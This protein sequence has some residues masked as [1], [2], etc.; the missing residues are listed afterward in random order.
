MP[1][2]L[3]AS[4]F[5]GGI[6]IFVAAEW[7]AALK[8]RLLRVAGRRKA[9]Q[10]A[11]EVSEGLILDLGAGEGYVAEA[12]S[13]GRRR[14]LL[15]DVGPFFRVDI[16]GVVYDGS[17]IPLRDGA[18][19]GVL[20]SL[21]LH[22]AKDPE[23]VIAEALRVARGCVIVTEST[24]RWQWERRLL[25]IVDRLANRTRGM[26]KHYQGPLRFRTVAQWEDTFESQGASVLRSE[27]LNAVGHR[28]HV[29][30]LSRNEAL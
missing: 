5:W 30:V 26:A 24:Y 17:Q 9:R 4:V 20:L 14:L 27:R 22:H 19:D 8:D 10:V 21:V 2:G 29:F 18:V 25:E 23:R 7:E 1:Q 13:N 16:P 11:R 3:P 15:M 28:H 6:G 12:L